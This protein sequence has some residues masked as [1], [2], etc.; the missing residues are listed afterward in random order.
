VSHAGPGSGPVTLQLDT[1]SKAYASVPAVSD[2]TLHVAPGSLT[3]LLGPSG[4]GKTTTLGI[5]SGLVTPDTGDVRVAGRS[6]LRTPADRRPVS[7]VFQR[8]LLFPHLDVEA[9]VGFGLR[10]R[11][12]PRDVVRARVH[13]ILDRVQLTG[14]GS[15]RVGELSGGQE[16]RVALARSLVLEPQVLLL[17]EPFSQLDASLRSEMRRLVVSLHRASG[18]TTVFVTHDQVEAV[19]VA[20]EVALMLDGRLE[21]QGSPETFYRTP[22]TLPAARFFSATNEIRGFVAAGVFTTTGGVVVG[23]DSSRRVPDGPAVLVARP[24]LVRLQDDGSGAALEVRTVD[25]RFAGTHLAVTVVTDDGQ[26]LTVHHPVDAPLTLGVQSRLRL[27]ADAP[28]FALA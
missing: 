23:T 7:T 11:R 21:G 1:V 18:L 26:R 2:L 10:M 8:P 14:L 24:E 28:V 27:P 13:E 3:A 25:A 9:N 15:R 12:M 6:L 4:C 16:Q 19:E 22:P 17:D 5:V 20:D